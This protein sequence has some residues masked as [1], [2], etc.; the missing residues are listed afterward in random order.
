[1]K[2]SILALIAAGVLAGCGGDGTNPFDDPV[3]VESPD[4]TESEDVDVNDP[5][6]TSDSKFVFDV[7]QKLTMN[8]VEYDETNDELVINNLPFDGPDGRYD[9]IGTS[10]GVAIYASRQTPTTGVVQHYAVFVRAAD[11]EGVAASGRDW[12]DFGFGGANVNRG[13]FALPPDGE[14]VYVGEYGAV[15][16]RN[17]GA[18]LELVTGDA[19]LLL[20]TLDLDPAS[21]QQG[22]V[23]GTITNRQRTDTLTGGSRINLPDLHLETVVYDS[24]DGTFDEGE[25]T[26]FDED[27]HQRD[28]G[29]YGGIIGGATGDQ[30]GVHVVIEGPAEMQEVFYEIV[31]YE[32]TTTDPLTGLTITTTATTNGLTEA[33]G[34]DDVLENFVDRGQSPGYLA[35]NRGGLPTGAVVTG[36]STES[37]MLESEFDAREIGVAVG[38]R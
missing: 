31:T 21:G 29:T 5:N 23:A 16:N 24:V 12:G 10:N 28:S 26:T 4:T 14:Y 30:M 18:S 35:V 1:M 2:P 22:T 27:G 11:L 20:D 8:S 32:V 13:E 36:S 3:E 34:A 17:D 7:E 37:I 38:T 33:G 25:A 9:R 6:V 19:T 15:R